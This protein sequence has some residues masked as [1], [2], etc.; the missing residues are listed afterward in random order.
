MSTQWAM[1]IGIDQYHES[2]GSL[3]YAGSDC[4]ALRESLVSGPMAFPEDQILLLDD[5][6]EPDH[7]PTF[8]NIHS[9][10]G[11]WLAAPKEDDLVLVYFA[12]HGRLE[13]G[14]T[15]LVPGDATLSSLHTL[16]I[17]LRHVHDVLE[18]CK[19]KRKLLILDACHSGAGRDVN[20]MTSAMQEAMAQGIGMYTLSACGPKE[21]SHE[22]DDKGQGVFSYFLSQALRGECLPAADGRL[23]V[24]RLYEWV[25]DR[26]AKWAAQHRCSQNPQ[27]FAQGTGSVVLTE[28]TPDHAAL[29]EQY[30]R[31]LEE[32][33]ARLA[34][35]ELR[36]TRERLT[37]ENVKPKPR[38][39]TSIKRCAIPE[40]REWVGNRGPYNWDYD[41]P[42]VTNWFGLLFWIIIGTVVVAIVTFLNSIVIGVL[43]TPIPLLLWSASLCISFNCWRNRYRLH[44]AELCSKA[45]D[46]IQGS[47]YAF[48]L[49][50]LGVDRASIVAAIVSLAELAESDDDSEQAYLLYKHAARKWKSPHAAQRLRELDES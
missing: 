46:Y 45:G 20:A 18:Q 4:R 1:L 15:Y 42:V 12:G 9:F 48:A 29:T 3:K 41:D 35:I 10:L 50:R 13:E 34:E 33:K 36:E 39:K 8:A 26:V 44:C 21:L 7:R 31:E 11:S 32:A 30:R 40:W 27:R 22:W 6:Q 38:K 28:S 2:L 24:D 16:G 47:A 19:A 14:K 37:Q 23:T 49:G 17:P 5:L 25:H 43:T